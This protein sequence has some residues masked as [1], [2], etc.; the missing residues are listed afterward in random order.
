MLE[1]DILAYTYYDTCMIQRKEYVL[2]EETGV[3]E[4]TLKTIASNVRCAVSKGDMPLLEE[5]GIQTYSASHTLFTYPYV[6]IKEGDFIT[7][8]V[9][10]QEMYFQASRPFKY[11]SHLEVPILFKEI[12]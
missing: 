12:V 4:S 9:Q 5:N 1:Q 2:D 7:A 11:V 10:G 6:D 8:N 3:S